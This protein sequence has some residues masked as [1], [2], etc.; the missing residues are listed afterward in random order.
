[1]MLGEALNRRADLQTRI[2]QVED[3]LCASVLAQEDEEPPE[4]PDDLLAELDSLADE[5]EHL[6]AQINHANA[7]TRIASGETVTEA[8]ARRDVLRLRQSALRAA[9]RAATRDGLSGLRYSRSEIRMVRMISVA[10]V[11]ARIDALA[12]ERRE[13]DNALQEHNWTT[14]ISE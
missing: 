13:L 4:R 10:E 3:R 12:K 11:Q 1:M 6:I 2:A 5:L 7:A 9:V 14:E 8:I